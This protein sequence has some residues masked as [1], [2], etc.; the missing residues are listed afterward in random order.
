MDGGVEAKCRYKLNI[1]MVAAASAYTV[2]DM[3]NS[4]NSMMEPVGGQVELKRT[5]GN[6]VA[7]N[8]SEKEIEAL[9]CRARVKAASQSI[10]ELDRES[11]LKWVMEQKEQGNLLYQQQDYQGACE[12]YLQACVGLDFGTTASQ[13][14]EIQ[15]KYQ[16]PLTCNIAACLMGLEKWNKVIQ[17]CTTALEIDPNCTKALRRRGLAYL[18]LENFTLAQEDLEKVLIFDPKIQ[19]QIDRIQHLRQK[20]KKQQRVHQKAMQKAV[21]TLYDEK[22]STPD[23]ISWLEWILSCC[24]SKRKVK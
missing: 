8:T 4:I 14:Q 16:L 17:I 9:D 10:V 15:Q 3:L 7:L 11:K 22:Q 12:I 21:G 18:K 13:K 2:S 5:N 23:R 20:R 1:K 19:I 6:G 24:S